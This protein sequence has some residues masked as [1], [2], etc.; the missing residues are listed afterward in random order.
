[1]GERGLEPISLEER[2]ETLGSTLT[3]FRNK[4]EAKG[5]AFFLRLKDKKA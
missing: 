4:C 2:G 1:M 3:A 5:F